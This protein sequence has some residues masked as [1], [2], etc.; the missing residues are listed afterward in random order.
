MATS[1]LFVV[2]GM[3]QY[4]TGWEAEVRRK[5]EEVAGRYAA[6]RADPAALWQEV[7]LVPVLYDD[8]LRATIDAWRTHAG[9]VASFARQHELFGGLDLD[10]LERFAG[11]DPSFFWTHAAD[12]VLYRFFKLQRAAVRARVA[13]QILDRVEALP[14]GAFD[15]CCVLAH[16]LGT[17]VIHDTLHTL[18]TSTFDGQAHPYGVLDSRFR[19]ITMLANTS[20]VLQDDIVAYDSVVRGGP[21]TSKTSNCSQFL[22]WHHEWDPFTLV[23]RYAPDLWDERWPANNNTFGSVAHFRHWNVHGFDHYLDHPRIHVPLL[24]LLTGRDAVPRKE[25]LAAVKAYE[26]FGGRLRTIPAIE[27]KVRELLTAVQGLR[28]DHG[29]AQVLEAIRAVQRIAG[30]LEGLVKP[31]LGQLADDLRTEVG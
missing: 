13:R 22:S 6:F 29:L 2:H 28:E 11:E 10:W 19:A 12:V 18:A 14:N 20:R 5:L 8:V 7:E 16:S 30:E 4:E 26:R 15:D 27:A 9:G 31:L 17:A 21:R 25:R 23:K 1:V 24:N 3:G